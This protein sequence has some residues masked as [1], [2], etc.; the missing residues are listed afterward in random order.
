MKFKKYIYS[1]IV[2]ILFISCITITSTFTKTTPKEEEVIE[3]YDYYITKS[4]MKIYYSRGD[5]TAKTDL[6]HYGD[7][8]TYRTVARDGYNFR[9]WFYS[10]N[11]SSQ[12][13]LTTMPAE[14]IS[15]IALWSPIAYTIVFNGNGG[16]SSTNA[17][18]QSM[19][20][21]YD[22]AQT[23]LSS[24]VFTR[25]YYTFLGWATSPNGSVVYQGGES[26]QNLTLTDGDTI[27]LYAV[28]SLNEVDITLNPNGG[29][30]F[31]G[32]SSTSITINAGTTILSSL[33]S[34]DPRRT[35]YTFEGWYYDEACT[36]RVEASDIASNAT[37]TLYAKWTLNEYQIIWD[38][39][40]GYFTDE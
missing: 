29:Q 27:N 31:N 38:P 30:N 10:S 13:T 37:Y 25:P 40:G 36:Q 17:T 3:E 19:N 20:A 16:K 4:G 39:N 32:S 14:N 7:T 18:S 26:I 23:A 33:T 1:I 22:I 6:I 9:G 8:I 2:F 15:L 34:L 24:S 11:Q 5:T 21:I 12:F 28:W 35:G